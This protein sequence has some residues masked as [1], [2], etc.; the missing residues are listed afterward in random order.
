MMNETKETPLI[1]RKVF[2]QYLEPAPVGLIRS[3][4]YSQTYQKAIR[5]LAMTPI[6]P[7]IM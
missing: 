2:Y 6:H 4:Q 5:I 3:F 7:K 1:A